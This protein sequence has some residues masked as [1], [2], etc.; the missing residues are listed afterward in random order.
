[1]R[2][3]GWR[4]LVGSLSVAVVVA[5]AL[6][7]GP[8]ASWSDFWSQ[9]AMLT[10]LVSSA[11][12]TVLTVTVIESWVGR[13]EAQ[14]AEAVRR[15]EQQRLT[16]VRAAAYNAV[17]RAAFAQ[18]RIMWF[19]VHGGELRRVPEFEI[20]ETHTRQL[21][22][23]LAQLGLAETSEHDVMRGAKPRPDLVERFPRLAQDEHWRRV[24]HDVLLDAVHA[25]RVLVAR[26]SSLL[27]TTE[28]SL[29]ALKDLAG[30]AEEF[31][32]IFVE[33]DP[34]RPA[35]NYHDDELRHRQRLWT[36]AF[37]NAVALEEALVDKGGERRSADGRFRTPGRLLLPPDDLDALKERDPAPTSSLRLY[38]EDPPAAP[39]PT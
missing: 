16:V 37:A 10:N 27:L 23:I 34:R 8:L 7:D 20:R 36:R 30:Q 5:L 18:R 14:H 6:T 19:L 12:F 13:Q 9:H 25:F 15:A 28:E 21:H 29:D 2:M 32:R 31:S 1:V 26:W 3:L 22:T 24:V 38:P 33:F 11:A 4:G 35:S 39:G 17:A